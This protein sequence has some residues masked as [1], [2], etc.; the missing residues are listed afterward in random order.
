MEAEVQSAS[1][2]TSVKRGPLPGPGTLL[3]QSWNLFKAHWLLFD[4]LILLPVLLFIP[5]ALIGGVGFF[6]GGEA[7]TS[8]GVGVPLIIIFSLVLVV[9][10]L[11]TQIALIK[12][13]QHEGAVG[14][15]QLLK[16]SWPLV[17]RYFLLSLLV[18]LTVLAG[19]IL[20]VIPGIIFSVWF[21]FSTYVLVVEGTGGTAAMR[22]SKF[23]ARGKFWGLVGRM[24]VIMLFTLVPSIIISA[25]E[26]EILTVLLQLV[27]AFVISPL[28][29]I[30]A[31]K[32]YQGAK[33]SS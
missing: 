12:A 2:D 33:A 9:V 23:Y 31:F 26:N 11:V 22:R 16:E 14:T 29:A 7:L 30:Y 27:S 15:K 1:V 32:L 17:W 25:F 4:W 6:L 24:L 18:G 10:G 5:L 13:I 28:S 20:L 19:F 3:S 8:G 21:M